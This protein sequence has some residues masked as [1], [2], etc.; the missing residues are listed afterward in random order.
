MLTHFLSDTMVRFRSDVCF[1][2]FIPITL[3]SRV[4][5]CVD[6]VHLLLA[7]H[8]GVCML[9]LVACCLLMLRIIACLICHTLTHTCLCLAD[10]SHD[11]ERADP[12]TAAYGRQ[13]FQQAYTRG[14]HAP[15]NR[16]TPDHGCPRLAGHTS[17]PG[18]RS[19]RD[20]IQG[21]A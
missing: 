2:I 13:C 12:I 17:V 4:S 21:V 10:T 20:L 15:V 6:L 3:R 11:Q 16:H 9:V 7:T 14:Q 18:C 19:A 5:A 8:I 1:R